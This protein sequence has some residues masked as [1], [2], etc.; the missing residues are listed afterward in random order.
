IGDTFHLDPMGTSIEGGMG[1]NAHLTSNIAL[2]GDVSYQY[3]LQKAG[4]SGIS[5]SGGIR[6]HF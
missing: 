4:V 5:V 6:Y 3:K 2:H 1:I